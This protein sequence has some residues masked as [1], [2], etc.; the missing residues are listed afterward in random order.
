[1]AVTIL[2]KAKRIVLPLSLPNKGLDMKL[3]IASILTAALLATSPALAAGGGGKMLDHEFS[4]DGIFGSFDQA[5]L[6]R[7][8]QIYEQ[9][10]S[11][12]HGMKHLSF[13]ALGEED[14]PGFSEEEVKAIA[15]NYEVPDE[16]GE[17][18]DTRP[19]KLF[20]YFPTPDAS[21]NPP[22]MSLLAKAR[23][24]G[25]LHIYSVLLGY[26]GSEKEAGGSYLYGNDGYGGYFGMAQPIYEGDVEY[27]DGTPETLE[28]YANDISAFLMW[29]AEPTMMERKQAGVTWISFLILFAV[30]VWFTNRKVWAKVKHPED[31]G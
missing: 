6:Q 13:R 20:D 16:E 27:A 24:G 12:C 25:P 7:G 10:C 14:G 4:F 19:A 22:D 8:F 18:G 29:A 31:H 28:Q 21:G 3:S 15:A 2:N 1:M 26:T 9:A 11:A 17:P 30:L 5:E 23:A